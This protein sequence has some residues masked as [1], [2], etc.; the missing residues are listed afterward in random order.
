MTVGP[1]RVFEANAKRGILL[2]ALGPLRD[3]AFHVH[4]KSRMTPFSPILITLC[5]PLKSKRFRQA[6][7]K[8]TGTHEI[9]G[10]AFN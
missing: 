6:M 8:G 5:D 10:N 2:L 3:I 7:R 1:W 4:E 9:L